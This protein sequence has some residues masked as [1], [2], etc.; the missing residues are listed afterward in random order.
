MSDRDDE[1]SISNL[2]IKLKELVTYLRERWLA[3]LLAGIIG[4]AVGIGY[5][6]IQAPQYEADC[7]FVL[8]EK[9]G[10]SAG[11]FA[12]LA[13]SLGVDVAGMMGGG[14]SLF[15]N[16]NL[17]DILQSRR[18]VETVLLSEVDTARVTHETLADLYLTFTRLDKF[19]DKKAGIAG[20]HFNGF[21]REQF[22]PLQDSILYV[23]CKKFIKL[24][25]VTDRTNKKT[26]IFK[27][28]VISKNE[29]FSKLMAERMV[30]ETKNFYI[31]IKTATAQKNLDRLQGRADSLLQLL[32][33]KS[34]ESAETQV[35]DA[36]PAMR[37]VQLPA[38]LAGRNE[39]LIGTVYTEV[40]KNLESTKTMLMVQ[41]PVIQL[42]D[43]PRLPLEDNKRGLLFCIVVFFAAG[44][45][46]CVI[47]L[48]A[49]PYLKKR[50]NV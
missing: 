2:V 42:I 48:F 33:G 36:N 46:L 29:Q 20:L 21:T 24:N 13:S 40:V 10:S 12:S 7:T 25:L 45:A 49:A 11:G 4:V 3:L 39:L 30:A 28:Q 31:G 23:I 43:M 38:K 27:V 19:Y 35:L 44:I 5:Y 9:S 8:D 14:S 41:T 50:G 22:S 15:A 1:V 26:Q 47:Y 6:Y 17:L 18:I 16:D 32:N 34:Y 37:T